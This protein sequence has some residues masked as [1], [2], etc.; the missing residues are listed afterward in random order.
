MIHLEEVI[1]MPNENKPL[2]DAEKVRAARRAYDKKYRETHREQIRA[3]N[4]R[5]WKK[6]Y[7]QSIA[8]KQHKQEGTEPDA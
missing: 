4:N 6:K 7:E 2:T 5:C 8:E 1:T 3:N